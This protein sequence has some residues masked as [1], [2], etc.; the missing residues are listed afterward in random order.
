MKFGLTSKQIQ[1]LN[2]V[3]SQYLQ[4]GTVIIYG[5]RVKNTYTKISD[6]DLVIKNSPLDRHQLAEL[7]DAIEESDFPY[8]CDLQL[9]E[10]ITNS[11]LKSHID[12]LGKVLF[13]FSVATKSK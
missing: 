4:T 7:M 10:R 3:F 8:L 13:N 1:V 11:Q 5:S 9:F 6:V 12:R 2:D